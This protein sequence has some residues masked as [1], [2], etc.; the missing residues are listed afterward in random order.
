MT[1]YYLAGT[2]V[3]ATNRPELEV[4]SKTG[5]STMEVTLTADGAF[6]VAQIENCVR[7]TETTIGVTITGGMLVFT[8]T[9][10]DFGVKPGYSII[11]MKD[12]VCTF[13]ET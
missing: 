1:D 2:W 7:G 12:A 4:V 10:N 5:N 11:V 9:V 6:T 3:A 8:G 13:E